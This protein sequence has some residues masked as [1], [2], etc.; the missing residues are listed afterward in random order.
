MGRVA[1]LPVVW[2]I[3]TFTPIRQ[4]MGNNTPGSTTITGIRAGLLILRTRGWFDAE[5]C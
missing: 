3:D 2:E 5:Y 1:K 4:V